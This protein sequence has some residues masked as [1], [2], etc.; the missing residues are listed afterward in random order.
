MKKYSA[1]FLVVA[2]IITLGATPFGVAQ[3]TST[4]APAETDASFE[5]LP[6]LK[7]SEILKPE[8]LKGPHHSVR[9]SVPTVSGEN[10]F[11]IDSDFGQFEAEGNEMLVIR[12]KEVYAIANLKEVSR[13][14]QFKDSLANAA[15]G[16]FNAAKKIV[17]DPGTTLSNVPKGVMKFMGRAGQ[18]VK[19]IGKKKE[20]DG[21]GANNVEK[22]TGQ[23]NAKRRIAVSMGIDPYSTNAV[24]QKQLDEIA[25]ASWAGGFIFSAGTMPIGGG[26]G[27]ALT[28]TSVSD[29]LD[30]VVNEKPPADLRQMNRAGLR[31]MGVGERDTEAFLSNPAFSPTRQ[32]AFVLNLK[33]L[34]GVANRAAFVHAAAAESDNESDALFCVLTSALMSKVHTGGH[35][36]ARIA[37]IG[38]FPACV[39][40]DGQ[41]ILALQWD[42]AAWTPA[43]ATIT[44][45]IEEL[46]KEVGNKGVLIALSGQASPRLKQELSNRGFTVHDRISPGPLQ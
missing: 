1:L 43:A 45:E 18:S 35:P 20:D 36:I 21:M 15:K 6:E 37:M 40:K 9:D 17:T 10:Q 8:F 3:S 27:I 26:V 2:I 44:T 41:V 12:V 11:V 34:D 13:T 22:M 7:A 39:A 38:S 28:A 23:S 33:S 5:Q 14:D 4:L 25:W 42:Y 32:T 46:A 19:N 30:K 24:L 16:T 31:S 29:S